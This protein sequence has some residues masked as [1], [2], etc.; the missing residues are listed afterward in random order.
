MTARIYIDNIN[1][2]RNINKEQVYM[3]GFMTYIHINKVIDKVGP[4]QYKESFVKIKNLITDLSTKRK[5]SY[6]EIVD[7]ILESA[8]EQEI[9]HG[10]VQGM[11][12]YD[13]FIVACDA[14]DN[15]YNR[16]TACTVQD[17]I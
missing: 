7:E 11:S 1:A 10:S 5:C 15:L 13:V 6:M 9:Q 16:P 8:E 3:S 14:L 4:R 2:E 17:I 12:A